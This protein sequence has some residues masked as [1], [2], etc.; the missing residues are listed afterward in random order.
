M[1][2]GVDS[3]F[4]F[5]ESQRIFDKSLRLICQYGIENLFW[6][7]PRS[8][9][10]R[11]MKLPARLLLAV[12][13]LSIGFLAPIVSPQTTLTN[14]QTSDRCASINMGRCHACPT[15]MGESTSAFGSSCCGTQSACCALYFT[16]ATQFS[17]RMQLIG[18]VGVRDEVVTTRVE[19]PPV[20]PP[21][22]TLFS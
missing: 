6:K 7:A 22:R 9:K 15:S 16:R 12:L 1:Q 8:D 20:P 13:T 14:P 11:A 19:R 2:V 5:S 3:I 18:R 21:R 4:T 10:L 17:S